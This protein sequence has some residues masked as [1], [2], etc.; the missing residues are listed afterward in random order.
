MSTPAAAKIRIWDVTVD[1]RACGGKKSSKAQCKQQQRFLD[2]L[3][4][5]DGYT[6]GEDSMLL[7]KGSR[8]L[9]QFVAETVGG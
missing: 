3:A 8:P 4:A 7:L 5:A 2:Q 6:V 1:G 9:L